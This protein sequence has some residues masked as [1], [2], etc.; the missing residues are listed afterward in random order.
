MKRKEKNLYKSIPLNRGGPGDYT[1]YAFIGYKQA[2]E[3]WA[4][5]LKR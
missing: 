5:W 2:D 3:K 4:I 1:Y